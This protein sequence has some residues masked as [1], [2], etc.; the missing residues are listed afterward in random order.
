MSRAADPERLRL[1]LRLAP[2]FVPDRLWQGFRVPTLRY[3][4]VH[5]LRVGPRKSLPSLARHHPGWLVYQQAALDHTVH[6]STFGAYRRNSRGGVA[7]CLVTTM[8]ASSASF[9]PTRASR[10]WPS[11]CA[12]KVKLSCD[13]RSGYGFAH[14]GGLAPENAMTCKGWASVTSGGPAARTRCSCPSSD[15]SWAGGRPSGTSCACPPDRRRQ[16]PR[17]RCCS[18]TRPGTACRARLPPRQCLS[19][20][21][22]GSSA[23][24][25]ESAMEV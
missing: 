23:A 2:D 5:T 1:S 20:S 14:A 15:P 17:R 12:W 7:A 10:T 18:P 4:D 25:G 11:A 13:G 8:T 16:S 6:R 21:E 22:K 24:E 9:T 3:V 19:A